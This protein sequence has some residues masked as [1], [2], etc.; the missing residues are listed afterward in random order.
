MNVTEYRVK[1]ASAC[2]EQGFAFRTGQDGDKVCFVA[3][4]AE[5]FGDGAGVSASF[6]VGFTGAVV[7]V[8]TRRFTP[9]SKCLGEVARGGGS[10]ECVAVELA[11]VRLGSRRGWWAG[12]LGR[13]ISRGC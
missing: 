13:S 10:P 8:C 4:V 5:D 12:W 3:A 1:V 11:L 2:G 7:G 9:D 6:H